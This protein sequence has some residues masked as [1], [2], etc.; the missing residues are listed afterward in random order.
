M[1]RTHHTKIQSRLARLN[2]RLGQIIQ[3]ADPLKDDGKPRTYP[4]YTQAKKALKLIPRNI[5]EA[6]EKSIRGETKTQKETVEQ[7]RV[8][9]RATDIPSERHASKKSERKAKRGA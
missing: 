8:E 1:T 5:R 7:K 2:I 6:Y 9:L 4:T 3:F